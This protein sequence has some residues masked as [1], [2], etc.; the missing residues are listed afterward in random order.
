MKRAIVFLET[1]LRPHISS[2][3]VVKI[4]KR[5]KPK[6]GVRS[7]NKLLLLTQAVI[8][9]LRGIA[10]NSSRNVSKHKARSIPSYVKPDK[11]A[12]GCGGNSQSS[13]GL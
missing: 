3:T 2:I 5:G 10:L 7:G 6:M 9:M 11:T 13:A 4:A 12:D 8:A 1:L